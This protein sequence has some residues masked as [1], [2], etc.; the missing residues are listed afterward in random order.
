MIGT[1][2]SHYRVV[3]KLG[4]GAM[5]IVYRALDVE[6]GRDV[7]LKFLSH[8][9]A[10]DR[11]AV[12][13][14]YREARAASAS[15]HPNICTIYEIDRTGDQFF[16]AMEYLQGLTLRD[17]IRE[18]PL[19][20]ETVLCLGIEIADALQAAHA[21]SIIHRDIKP[22]NIFVT[23]GGHAKILDFGLA[24]FAGLGDGEAGLAMPQPCPKD[25]TS[26]L[27]QTGTTVG[28]VAYMSPEQARGGKLDARS[29]LFSFG[30]LLYEMATGRRPFRGED[31]ETILDM[32]ANRPHA[33]PAR[34][35]PNVPGELERI[36]NKALEKDPDAR[37]QSAA[38][39]AADL[40]SLKRQHDISKA[41]A[42]DPSATSRSKISG[43][44][45]AATLMAIVLAS[46]AAWSRRAKSASEQGTANPAAFDFYSKGRYYWN[47]RTGPDIR[48]SI[49]YFNQA[50]AADPGYAMAYTGLADAYSILPQYGGNPSDA[51][52]NSS[53]A[54]RK[55]LELNPSLAHPHA[56]LASNAIEYDWDFAAGA[57]QYQRA[58]E[59][60]PNNVTARR[61]FAQ[62]MSWI[63]G[64]ETRA[65]AEANH[66]FQLDPLSPINTATLG[67]VHITARRYDDAL[68]TCKNL[69]IQ[70]PTFAGAHLCLAQA[71]WGKGMY[72]K[73][74]SEFQ[75]YAQ[76]SK[77][78]DSSDFAAALEKGFH[79]SGW[80]GALSN[81]VQ[82]R[83]AQR[84]AG[85]GSPYELAILYAGLGDRDKA[86]TWLETAYQRRDIGLIRLKTD[87]LLDSLRSDPRFVAMMGKVGLPK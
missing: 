64:N 35:N 45:L 26:D 70:N 46:G 43:L 87:F 7:A 29:D 6:L 52:P 36:I 2:I 22:A 49:S 86:F 59:L 39:L 69:T 55:A 82:V 47:K 25:H 11:R 58:F 63:G 72:S 27:T 67:T 71:Y 34:V 57:S 75:Q 3:E 8:T 44:W 30:V 74:I 83:L 33:S 41:I 37:Y 61:W 18:K 85:H 76:L 81:A 62:D 53:A 65:L 9:V 12:E 21:K 23:E 4:D 68:V 1:T 73:V 60:D 14:L 28:T 31:W 13:R 16:I 56:I 51:Y 54:A 15:N 80:K 79:L 48:T 32:I 42:S 78:R 40:R 17:R 66:A 38:G 5:G 50:I 19:D 84:E 24:K 20:I 10:H 77:D